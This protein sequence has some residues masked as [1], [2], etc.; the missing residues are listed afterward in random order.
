MK[1]DFIIIGGGMSG[2]VCAFILS[3]KG[4]K[5]IVLEK[6]PQLGGGLQIFSREKTLFETGVHYVGGLEQGQTLNQLF[7]Y[8]EL[9][10]KI[11][12][13]QMDKYCF[14]KIHFGNE[15][16]YYALAQGYDMFITNL[17]KDFPYEEKGIIEYCEKIK[18]ACS[19]FSLYNLNDQTDYPVSNEEVKSVDEVIESIIREG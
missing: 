15:S 18:K 19:T 2:L 17:V 3:K 9:M 10:D 6:N 12:I 1:Y 14:D 16:K 11:K 13:K 8:L 5:V 7:K 4:K